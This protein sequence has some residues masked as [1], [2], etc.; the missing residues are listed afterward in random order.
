VPGHHP[1]RRQHFVG[2]GRGRG[3][4]VA[5]R[6]GRDQPR[7][8]HDGPAQV[9]DRLVGVPQ[10]SPFAMHAGESV[11][12]YLLGILGHR[13]GNQCPDQKCRQAQQRL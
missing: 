8:A 12:D 6:R 13:L 3:R 2:G 11:V 9:S 1:Q 5:V 10:P 4:T 7:A